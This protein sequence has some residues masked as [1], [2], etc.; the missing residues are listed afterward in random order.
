MSIL[1]GVNR[2]G[3]RLFR[4]WNGAFVY[5]QLKIKKNSKTLGKYA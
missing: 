1:F 5:F 4:K 3:Y 2:L